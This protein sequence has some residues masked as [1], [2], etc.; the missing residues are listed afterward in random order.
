MAKFEPFRRPKDPNQS[1]PYGVDFA[2]EL[3][4]EPGITLSEPTVVAYLEKKTTDVDWVPHPRVTVSNV[5]LTGK[6]VTAMI[7]GGQL[8]DSVVL[9]FGAT[10]SD[11]GNVVCSKILKIEDR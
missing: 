7:A 11:G 5:V 8:R 10:R 3:T 6:V 2:V 4:L 1:L 9:T